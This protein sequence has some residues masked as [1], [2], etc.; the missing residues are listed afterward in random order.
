MQE[1][2]AGHKNG[3]YSPGA[4]CLSLRRKDFNMR[5]RGRQVD[6]KEVL[7]DLDVPPWRRQAIPLLIWQNEVVAVSNLAISERFRNPADGA[8][9][10]DYCRLLTV[11]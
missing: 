4:L 10:A 9:K 8:A 1:V 5:W 7:R 3:F 6:I 11:K 2:A